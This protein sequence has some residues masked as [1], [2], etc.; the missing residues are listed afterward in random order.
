ML[1][2]DNSHNYSGSAIEEIQED[3][4]EEESG[5]NVM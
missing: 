1:C 4:E 2:D 5:L 3:E